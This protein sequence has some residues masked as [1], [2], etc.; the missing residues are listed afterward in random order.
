M[1][2]SRAN[3]THPPKS[4][5][6]NKTTVQNVLAI[7]MQTNKTTHAG[8]GY[9][10]KET[11]VKGNFRALEHVRYSFLLLLLLLLVPKIH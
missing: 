5:W 3:L 7:V 1:T 10:H 8:S 9:K 2:V 6:D 4:L 11:K